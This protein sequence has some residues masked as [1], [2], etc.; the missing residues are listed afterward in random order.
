MPKLVVKLEIDSDEYLD[1]ETMFRDVEEAIVELFTGTDFC[2]DFDTL[3]VTLES[4]TLSQHELDIIRF[5][6]ES[7][8]DD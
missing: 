7:G 1:A 5:Q 3:R 2:E 6:G 8:K 4:S